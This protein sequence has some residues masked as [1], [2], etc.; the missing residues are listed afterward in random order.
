MIL[1][2]MQGFA[3]YVTFPK[4]SIW[5][6]MIWQQSLVLIVSCAIETSI[7]LTTV[8]S[9]I[10]RVTMQYTTKYLEQSKEIK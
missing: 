7:Q 4:Q 5:E 3:V 6:I 2:F 9:D 1:E 10:F 8:F